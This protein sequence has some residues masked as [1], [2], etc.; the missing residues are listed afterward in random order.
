LH[1]YSLSLESPTNL[2]HWWGFSFRGYEMS[3]DTYV[4][5]SLRDGTTVKREFEY[6]ELRNWD[7]IT[8]AQVQAFHNPRVPGVHTSNSLWEL[9]VTYTKQTNAHAIDPA[10]TPFEPAHF[11]MGRGAEVKRRANTMLRDKHENAGVFKPFCDAWKRAKKQVKNNPPDASHP[12]QEAFA[13]FQT[14]RLGRGGTQVFALNYAFLIP[15]SE[16]DPATGEVVNSCVVTFVQNRTRLRTTILKVTN[17]QNDRACVFN[18]YVDQVHRYA[19]KQTQSSIAIQRVI[20]GE[21][22]EIE[23]SRTVWPTEAALAQAVEQPQPRTEDQDRVDQDIWQVESLEGSQGMGTADEP[24]RATGHGEAS[25]VGGAIASHMDDQGSPQARQV[26]GPV[27]EPDSRFPASIAARIR[28]LEGQRMDSPAPQP[29]VDG[30]AG[31]GKDSGRPSLSP[32]AGSDRDGDLT[33]DQIQAMKDE[34][35]CQVPAGCKR[36][37]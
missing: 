20:E 17:N 31:E 10:N 30:R 27:S 36:A 25:S 13:G 28:Q 18:G 2:D 29:Q 33:D 12:V 22:H 32:E 6:F 35:T 14:E 4:L 26:Q 23:Q 7:E 3:K 19:Q 37:S 16:I 11:A 5:R 15:V 8:W 24:A 1:V 21:T 34:A 9:K